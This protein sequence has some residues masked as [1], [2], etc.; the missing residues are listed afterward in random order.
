MR[1]SLTV[2]DGGGPVATSYVWDVNRSL[3]VVLQDGTNTY[4]YGLDLISATD[5]SNNHT[6]YQYDGLGSTVA[7]ADDTGTITDTYE[8]DVFGAVRASTGSSTN[9]WLFTGEQHDSDSGLQFLRA[10]YYDPST[11]RF[12]SR[13]PIPSNN[14]YAYAFN[15]PVYFVDPYGQ[16]PS[17]PNPVKAVKS[18]ANAVADV[19]N[20]VYNSA[21]SVANA[22]GPYVAQCAIWGAGGVVVGGIGAAAGCAIGLGRSLGLSPN[23]KN[24]AV[25]GTLTLAGAGLAAAGIWSCSVMIP[26][27]LAAGPIGW[28][29]VTH[30][31]GVCGGITAFGVVFAACGVEIAFVGKCGIDLPASRAEAMEARSATGSGKE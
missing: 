17:V 13:D 6:Y 18:T 8:Y 23:W 10:R 22:V 19:G 26:D 3:P 31:A 29:T 1:T 4:V 21:T 14:A 20:A 12:M 30:T 7:L 27:E 24:V 2:D 25:G 9:P 11:G 5:G 15:N 28:I 16:W